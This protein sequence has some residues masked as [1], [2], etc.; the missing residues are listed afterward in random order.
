M[1]DIVVNLFCFVVL[2]FL[3]TYILYK[4]SGAKNWKEYREINKIQKDEENKR[5]LNFFKIFLPSNMNTTQKVLLLIFLMSFIAWITFGAQT[6]TS[7]R[8]G[9][10]LHEWYQIVLL[11]T[12]LGSFVGIY[13]FKD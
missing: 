6:S 9:R 13:L 10:Y 7:I 3:M 2:P 11:P 1:L 12:W 4:R 5:I 8:Y